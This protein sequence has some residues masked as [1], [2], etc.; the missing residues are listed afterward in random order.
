MFMLYKSDESIPNFYQLIFLSILVDF[1]AVRFV[2]NFPLTI[3]RLL[4][5]IGFIQVEY[6]G[7][8]AKIFFDSIAPSSI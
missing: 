6:L 3:V 2:L 8:K 4:C 1:P 5:S 7:R